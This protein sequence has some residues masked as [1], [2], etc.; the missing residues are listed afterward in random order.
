MGNCKTDN[1]LV[2][3]ELSTGTFKLFI[4]KALAFANIGKNN[5]IFFGE[6]RP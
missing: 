4:K 5:T 6:S 3:A 1:Y 2:V